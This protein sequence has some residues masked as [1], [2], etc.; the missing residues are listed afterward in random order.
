M[1]STCSCTSVELLVAALDIT[2]STGHQDDHFVE[3]CP[4][5]IQQ[6]VQYGRSDTASNLMENIWVP[7][8]GTLLFNLGLV[9]YLALSMPPIFFANCYTGQAG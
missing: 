9:V 6:P 8:A 4:V 3:L 7:G 2:Y 5:F 1:E